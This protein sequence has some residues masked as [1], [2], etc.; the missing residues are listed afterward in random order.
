MSLSRWS[1]SVLLA[2]VLGCVPAAPQAT[3][4]AAHGASVIARGESLPSRVI[5]ERVARVFGVAGTR[6]LI[7]RPPAEGEPFRILQLAAD[8]ALSSLPVEGMP[9]STHAIAPD[10]R[11]SEMRLPTALYGSPDRALWLATTNSASSFGG[12]ARV[13]RLQQDKLGATSD[14]WECVSGCHDQDSENAWAARFGSVPFKGSPR[15]LRLGLE[16]SG[17]LIALCNKERVGCEYYLLPI[18]LPMSA[19]EALGKARALGTWSASSELDDGSV[20]LGSAST[21][22]LGTSRM[23][24]ITAKSTRSWALPRPGLRGLQA[25]SAERVLLRMSERVMLLEG[26]VLHD[27]TLPTDASADAVYLDAGGAL[28]SIDSS[29]T[30]WTAA[31]G[32]RGAW[33]ARGH[34]AA[35]RAGTRILG[36]TAD[37]LWLLAPRVDGSADGELVRIELAGIPHRENFN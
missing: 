33:R 23:L 2:S 16:G 14:S 34:V 32:E 29:G 22:G 9:V 17:R 36:A 20:L 35:A 8:G 31:A 28:W 18:P 6:Y 21:G 24:L 1:F 19:A 10:A 12:P 27:V 11:G 15:F 13:Y 37:V 25:H 3:N 30:V 7:V 5:A 26:G 4:V